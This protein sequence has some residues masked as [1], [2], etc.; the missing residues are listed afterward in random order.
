MR[1]YLDNCSYNRPFD[2][3]TQLKVRLET[4]AKLRVQ[5]MMRSGEA[6]RFVSLM[7]RGAGDYTEWRRNHLYAEETV[8]SLAEKAR[9]TGAMLRDMDKVNA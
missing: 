1:V 8:H 9:K 2:E 4:E 5:A 3:Q 6:E 7:N